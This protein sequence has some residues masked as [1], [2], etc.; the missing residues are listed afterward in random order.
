M[1]SGCINIYNKPYSENEKAKWWKHVVGKQINDI[2]YKEIPEGIF[3][4]EQVNSQNE[5]SRQ[6]M[7]SFHYEMTTT[8]I[9]TSSDLG[10]IKPLD[11][12][13][14]RDEIWVVDDVQKKPVKSQLQYSKRP[15]YV[16][17]LS[18]KG[19]GSE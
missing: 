1:G 12:V 19:A 7:S 14:W 13:K 5:S 8:T 10:K 16:Y 4:C 17:Y 15:S 9:K 18:L 11:I 2:V 3:Y 6:M